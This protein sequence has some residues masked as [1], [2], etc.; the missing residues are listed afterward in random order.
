MTQSIRL[1]QQTSGQL[2]AKQTADL[3]SLITNGVQNI[4]KQAT[5]ATS[6]TGGAG[7]ESQDN[8]NIQNSIQNIV[9][10]TVSDSN[11]NALVSE[12]LNKQDGKIL[13]KGNCNGKV[14]ISQ[15]IVADV[16]AKNVIEAVQQAMADNQAV[17]SVFNQGDQT[18]K[19]TSKGF[20]EMIDSLFKGIAGLLPWTTLGP[21]AGGICLMCCM[22][23][24]LIG[25]FMMFGPH[26]P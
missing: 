22:C 19:S 1:T 2:N 3:R 5:D 23:V 17:A 18:A 20:A 6:S 9:N 7:A 16:I 4:T 24:L 13:I 21:I 11:Y 14:T 26:N 15:T 12:T 8:V 25:A 10:T